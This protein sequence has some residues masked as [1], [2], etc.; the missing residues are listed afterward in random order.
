MRVSLDWLRSL[1]DSGLDAAAISRHLVN[2][3]LEVSAVWQVPAPCEKIVTA[4]VTGIRQMPRTNLQGL[5]VDAG[6]A[7]KFNV[8]SGAPHLRE[9]MVGALALPGATLPDGRV[10][11]AREY[12]GEP[13]EAM[14]CAAAEIG[15]G[16][17]S[18]RL[19]TFADDTPEGEVV[20]DL[21]GLP[22]TCLEIDLT[23]N[24]GD[25][26]SMLGVA[27]ELH[28]GTGAGLTLPE[29]ETVEAVQRHE[30]AVNVTA[31]DA[32]PRYSGRVISEIDP[33][34]VTPL[35][36]SE[37]LRR[38]GL[39]PTYPVVDVLNYVMLE[40][41]QPLHAFDMGKLHG[42]LTV[43]MAR[44]GET[45]TLI[46]GTEPIELAS[47]MLVIADKRGPV[48]L[49]GV[50][51]GEESAISGRTTE[52]FLES[53]FFAPAAIRGRARRL[54]LVTEAA[55][56][57]ER[58]VDPE[59]APVA[60]ERATALIASICGGR[61]G[62]VVLRQEAGH[63]PARDVIELTTT[64]VRRLTGLDFST[65]AVGSILERLGF[66]VRITGDFSLAVT[67]P[68]ARFDI[69]GDADL[70]EEVA[71]IA[72]FDSIPAIAPTRHLSPMHHDAVSSL[73][74]RLRRLIA[75]RG[76]D[77]AVTMSFAEAERDAALAPA[78]TRALSLHNPL[79]AR[80]GI[81]RRS[82]WPGL[83]EALAH[84]AARQAERVRLFEIGAVFFDGTEQVEQLAGVACGPLLPEQWG[85]SGRMADFFDIKGDVHQLLVSA[86][87]PS[88][89]IEYIP[90]KRQALASG[91]R[92]SALVADRVV[93]DF[94]VLAP[95]LVKEWGL[96]ADVLVFE[97][98]LDALPESR[99]LQA[100]PVAR[101]PG[102]RRDLALVA[103]QAISAAEL[104]LSVRK[105]GGS[106]LREVRIFDV[107]SGEGIPED[108]RSIGL[109]LI[110]QDFSRTLTDAE[111]DAAVSAIVA[112]LG[113]EKGAYVRS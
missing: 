108:S 27:R 10:I 107:Y 4:R 68:S 96:P 70:V 30:L 39:R 25:C 34:A 32:C 49:A 76:Y 65:E 75:A 33:D 22:D 111:V 19:L 8:V 60:L 62:P 86:G 71:R 43:R 106:R 64:T 17:V 21:Y 94:G 28:A 7:G 66:H 79:S 14:L 15:L 77:E 103:K 38:A 101:F 95:R 2:Q 110:F 112:G 31:P 3:G 89:A 20:A 99:R 51:G 113:E 91:R 52:V 58:G 61:P 69:D 1:C 88:E 23:P 46:G 100:G 90:S 67:A 82:L 48:A 74:D 26:L 85:E 55:H 59:L 16:E 98:N 36:M 44:P 56:R 57:Y 92:A 102:V 13:S 54:G 53:A 35:W 42:G 105:H 11:E 37:R 40:L 12:Q 80:E 9:G 97:I 93:A 104:E 72:G 73:R 63:L 84:N 45:L 109:G 47:D 18:D 5:T 87:V 41:G 78:S 50:M 81:L 6:A 29:T 24:R 83:I